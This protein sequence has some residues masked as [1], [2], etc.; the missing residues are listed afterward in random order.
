MSAS[1]KVRT[2]DETIKNTVD[3]H[4]GSLLQLYIK[5]SCF[6]NFNLISLAWLLAYFVGTSKNVVRSLAYVHKIQDLD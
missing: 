2:N 6:L 4:F 1:H 3:A 5:H